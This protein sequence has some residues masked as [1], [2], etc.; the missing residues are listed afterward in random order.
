MALILVVD[1][2]PAIR[3]LLCRWL[4]KEGHDTAEAEDAGA[5]LDVMAATP[6]QVV[7]C[8]IRMPGR[9]GLWLTAEL[10]ERYPTTAIILATGVSTVPA[11]TSLQAGVLAYLVKPF[12]RDNLRGALNAALKWNADAAMFGL[13]ADPGIDQV[14]GW[15]ESIDDVKP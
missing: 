10:R 7:F 9:D 1:D 5:A 3:Q 12:Q 14:A 13:R 11:Q 2:E 15:L 4:A 8:D 6:A